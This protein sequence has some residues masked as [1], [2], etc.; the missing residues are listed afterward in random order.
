MTSKLDKWIRTLDL[1]FA[2][3]EKKQGRQVA[4]EKSKIQGDLNG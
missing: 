2:L 1:V 3:A 4:N